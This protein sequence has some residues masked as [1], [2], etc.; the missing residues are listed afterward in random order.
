LG[1]SISPTGVR[2]TELGGSKVIQPSCLY[3]TRIT[4]K[5][6]PSKSL[7]NSALVKFKRAYGSLKE[8]AKTILEE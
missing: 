2:S 4:M 5:C 6:V 8:L 1:N 3:N 7:S